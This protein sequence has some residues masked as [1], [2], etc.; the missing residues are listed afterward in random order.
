MESDPPTVPLGR[1]RPLFLDP[2][3]IIVCSITLIAVM[4]V[5]SIAP[6]LPAIVAA[7]GISI[8]ESG[9]L[10]AAF[11][12]PGLVLTP[13][14][15][16]LADRLG[17]KRV[18]VPSLVV[19]AAAGHGC[20]YA[21]DFGELLALRI[22]QGAGAAA[23]G[24]LNA[25]L[26]GD[27]Y[28]GNARATAMGYSGGMF[29]ASAAGWPLV[30][31]AVAVFGWRYP[32]VLP[33]LAIP[34]AL[35][36]AYG[37]RNPEPRGS[38]RLS[39]YFSKVAAGVRQGSVAVLFFAGFA[40]FTLLYGAKITFLPFLLEAEFGADSV[41]I[42][43]VFGVSSTGA[44]VGSVFLGA[45]TRRF[46]ARSIL[47]G[48]FAAMVA[49]LAATP[50]AATMWIIMLWG[51]LFSAG[52]GIAVAMAMVLLTET[53]PAEQR[54]AVM[55]LN[56]MMFRLGQTVGPLLMAALFVGGGMD[57]VFWGGAVVGVVAMLLLV[58]ARESQPRE[59]CPL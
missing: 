39:V 59:S 13:I 41:D 36:I 3:L 19:F 6:V 44:I 50:L 51:A 47:L 43:V 31:G 57:A 9:W 20:M 54:G 46:R 48:A 22:I 37:L 35:I 28:T 26:I 7:F 30:G 56:G 45:L 34:V 11:T 12:V 55:A 33:L 2:N 38:D 16:F 53:A 27:L 24:S 14:T 23:L 5:S 21:E 1:T 18:L 42:G 15:G 32:F 29:S 4:G 58:Y 40:A 52:H 17:R 10:I 49:A 8:E 25:T